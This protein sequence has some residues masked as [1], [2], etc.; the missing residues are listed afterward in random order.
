VTD[1]RPLVRICIPTHNAGKTLRET[2]VSV[3]AQTYAPLE[4]MIID[5]ASTD[6]TVEVA[7]SFNDPRVSVLRNVE[8]IG[9]ERNFT[10][11]IE[12]SAGAYTAIFHA[13]D[14]YMP[15]MVEKQIAFLELHPD[16]G[17]VFVNAALIDSKG[18]KLGNYG[19]GAAHQSKDNLYDFTSIMKMI[20]RHSNFL[21]CPSAM[22]RTSV[23]RND[24]IKWNGDDFKTSADLDVWLRI[25]QKHRI[26]I[27]PEPLIHYRISLLQGSAMLRARTE[28]ADFFLVLDH[29]LQQTHVLS[30]LTPDD[31]RNFSRLERTDRIVRAVN[32]YLQDEAPRAWQLSQGLLR[33]DALRA[34]FE[35]WRGAATL[36]AGLLVRIM[37]VLRCPP[38][39]KFLLL[40][41][42][43]FANK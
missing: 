39:G 4:V 41:M 21:I 22:V 35:S 18:H 33:L 37:I 27:L 29:Y 26:G 25:L 13:D 24:I 7:E 3:L 2:L 8:N 1:I 5:N 43:R 36:M 34:A 38:L 11:C 31:W 19:L 20:L 28:R 32:L 12:Q 23:Y 42:K 17:A 40:R 16:A 6:D 10:R 9:G 30:L 15:T 14:V